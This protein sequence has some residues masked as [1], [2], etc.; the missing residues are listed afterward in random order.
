[1]EEHSDGS[2]DEDT[3]NWAEDLTR[4]AWERK[5]FDVQD[6]RV[7]YNNVDKMPL[8]MLKEEAKVIAVRVKQT[9]GLRT[10]V[11]VASV[12]EEKIYSLF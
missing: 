9:L 5:G 12:P 6:V 10:N 1:M 11:S 7:V 2:E 3:T 4:E 8:E